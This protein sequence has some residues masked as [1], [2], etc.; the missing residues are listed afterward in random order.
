[1]Q[2]TVRQLGVQ[3]IYHL[4]LSYSVWVVSC[5]LLLAVLPF[6][7]TWLL[8]EQ[9]EQKGMWPA[10]LPPNWKSANSSSAAGY[11]ASDFY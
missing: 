4:T 6:C 10:L 2:G 5:S 9:K 1:M 7:W 3:H 8:W 11:A